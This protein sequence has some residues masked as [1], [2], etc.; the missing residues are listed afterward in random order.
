MTDEQVAMIV[1][2][3]AS[4]GEHICLCLSAVVVAIWCWS[5]VQ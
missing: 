2:E 5:V 4:C 1:E 3:I